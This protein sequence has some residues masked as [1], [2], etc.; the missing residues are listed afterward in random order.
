M[1]A[2]KKVQAASSGK[3]DNSKD[4]KKAG[5]DLSNKINLEIQEE[6]VKKKAEALGDKFGYINLISTPINADLYEFWDLKE[7]KEALIIPFLE[8]VL[9]LGLQ[10][11]IQIF[12]KQKRF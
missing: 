10:L 9:K 11:M 6:I 2:K 8:L 1:D 7:L 12:Q 4:D 5:L 3:R